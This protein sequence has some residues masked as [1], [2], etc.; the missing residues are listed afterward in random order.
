MATN[1]LQFCRDPGI[2]V[3]KITWDQLDNLVDKNKPASFTLPDLPDDT[4]RGILKGT[5]NTVETLYKNI[6]CRNNLVWKN[7][8][9]RRENFVSGLRIT[10]FPRIF[11]GIIDLFLHP[12]S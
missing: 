4:F 9:S 2:K 7:I 11:L 6:A 8:F 3:M 1:F 10:S 5:E 12:D